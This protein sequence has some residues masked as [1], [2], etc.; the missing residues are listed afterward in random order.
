MDTIIS[1]IVASI[2][3][4]FSMFLLKK[5]AGK[6]KNGLLVGLIFFCIAFFT[7]TFL[8]SN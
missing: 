6:E 1:I 4:I 2:F 5:H 8:T 3:S 7:Y